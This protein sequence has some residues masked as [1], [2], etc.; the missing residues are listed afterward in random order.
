MMD[1]N[2]PSNTPGPQA[3]RRAT[4]SHN[5]TSA[6]YGCGWMVQ[7]LRSLAVLTEAPGLVYSTQ[8]GVAHKQLKL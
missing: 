4:I 8:H 6:D 7:W 2:Y 5:K 3:D 1:N